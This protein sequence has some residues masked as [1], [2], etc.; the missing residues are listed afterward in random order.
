ML[1]DGDMATLS[2]RD[3][4]CSHQATQKFRFSISLAFPKF[5]SEV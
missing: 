1:I 3:I 5:T 2:V 4:C